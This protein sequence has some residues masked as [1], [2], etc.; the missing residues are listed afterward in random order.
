MASGA[1]D[2]VQLRRYD[3]SQPW[4]FRMQGGREFGLPL[5]IV[6]VS[7][8][9]IAGKAG[10]QN[11]DAILEICGTNVTGWGH[12]E[13]KNEMMRAGNEVDLRVARG[14]VNTSDPKVKA[15]C[16]V[17]QGNKRVELDE[18]SINPHMNEG[19]M[20]RNVTPKTYKILEAQLGSAEPAPSA[21][22]QQPAQQMAPVHA[23]PAQPKPSSI[24]DRKKQDRSDYL[25]AQ[26][27]TIQKTYGEQ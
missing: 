13:A 24:F 18:G 26:G 22:S 14:V 21:L 20:F 16:G 12:Q 1:S 19:S 25:V 27:Q 7:P 3:T 15:A 17:G 5:F 6:N 2:L 4:G 10:L 9:S 11:G 8:K 23:Q